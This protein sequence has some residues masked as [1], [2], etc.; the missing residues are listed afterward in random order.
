MKHALWIPLLFVLDATAQTVLPPFAA[1][2]QISSIG[3][4]SGLASYG[5]TAFAPNDPN[6]LL[7]SPWPS[8]AILAVPLV[9]NAQGF[10]TG[11]GAATPVYT[12]SGTDGGLAFGP[13][14]VLFATWFGPNRLQQIRPGSTTVNRSDDLTPLGVVGTLGT[15]TFVPA[16]L[17]GAGRCKVASYS[18]NVFYDLPLT[19]DGTGTYAP[20]TATGTPISGFPE[21]LVYA[22]LNTPLL[23][24][25][26]LVG[27][28]LAG[29]I[30]AYQIGPTGDPIVST[31]QVV[32]T[33]VDSIG[34]G[35]VDPV[36]GDFVFL[37]ASGVITVLHNDAACGTFTSYGPP[38]PG[39]LGTPT[40]SATGCVHVGSSFSL[41]ATG[42]ASATGLIAL[43]FQATSQQWFNVTVLQTLDIAYGDTLGAT[44][45]STR[46]FVI[47]AMPQLASTH[48]YFQSAYVD[49]STISGII[50]SGGLDV[51]IR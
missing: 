47:P 34:G 26:L 17:P 43:G 37:R 15:C 25:Q 28:W 20:G 4:P 23:G 22:P 36:T 50:A 9:R 18:G 49:P 48:V 45:S 29:Q 10:L 12:V 35:V 14:G 24:G 19:A 31:R 39:A 27:E 11:A 8:S 3:A 33:G 21:G 41:D 5:G 32:A 40:I 42:P 7:V 16:G 44:G 30:A 1:V 13:G 2:W 38:S 6:T 46:S 51:L